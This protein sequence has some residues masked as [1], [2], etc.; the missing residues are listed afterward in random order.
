MSARTA[1]RSESVLQRRRSSRIAKRRG[2]SIASG[3]KGARVPCSIW[4]ISDHGARLAAP[5]PETLPSTF[6]LLLNSDGTSTKYCRVAWRSNT[7]VGVQFV[8]ASFGETC[9]PPLRPPAARSSPAAAPPAAEL[10]K[11][12]M[13]PQLASLR[14]AGAFSESSSHGVSGLSSLAG[15]FVT[16]LIGA[17][18]LFY[19]AASRMGDEETSW[20]RDVCDSARNLCEHPEITGISAL[21]MILVFMARKGMDRE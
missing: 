8:D 13:G 16:L 18:A 3:G 9:A 12:T 15:L 10:G 11:L 1:W 7:H 6:T 2:A 5:H 20:T 19:Y 21:I 17:T 14:R 4:D